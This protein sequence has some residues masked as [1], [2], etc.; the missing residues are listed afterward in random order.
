MPNEQLQFDARPGCPRC[1]LDRVRFVH[2]CTLPRFTLQPGDEWFVPQERIQPDGSFM[3]GAGIVLARDY[4][5]VEHDHHRA[6][7]C[8]PMPPRKSAWVQEFGG[9]PR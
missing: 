7:G 4:E 2:A 9:A 5:L 6:T 8:C 3:L 1:R